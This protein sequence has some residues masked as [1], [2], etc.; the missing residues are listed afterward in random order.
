METVS[1]THTC[2]CVPWPWALRRGKG[3]GIE[4]TYPPVLPLLFCCRAQAQSSPC[5][6][7]SES[8]FVVLRKS[9]VRIAVRTRAPQETL[10]AF[11]AMRNANAHATQLL[12]EPAPG[13]CDAQSCC[14]GLGNSR[15][16]A[17]RGPIACGCYT[18]GW[19]HGRTLL[20]CGGYA[21][22]ESW[23]TLKHLGKGRAKI[24]GGSG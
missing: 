8:L 20:T 9:M 3:Q 2:R 11:S 23:N 22:N 16:T 14:R 19:A 18:S 17:A 5:M 10:K 4:V 15:A 13:F 21:R 12:R 6:L 7:S 24:Q 1:E